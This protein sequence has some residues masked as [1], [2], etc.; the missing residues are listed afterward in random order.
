MKITL[1]IVNETVL[2]HTEFE[3]PTL[4]SLFFSFRDIEEC[5]FVRSCAQFILSKIWWSLFNV[6]IYIWSLFKAKI[7]YGALMKPSEIF[8]FE[9]II[10]FSAS[11]FFLAA[12]NKKF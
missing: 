8:F 3:I 1:K 12:D 7:N 6:Q 11:L 4:H 2:L 9:D 10:N 5:A